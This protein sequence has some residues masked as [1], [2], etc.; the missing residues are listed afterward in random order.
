M[1]KLIFSFLIGSLSM[2][3]FANTMTEDLMLSLETDQNFSMKAKLSPN[4]KITAEISKNGIMQQCSGSYK[5][6]ISK[7]VIVTIGLVLITFEG[8]CSAFDMAGSFE[9]K[10]LEKIKVGQSMDFLF[11]FLK[12]INSE[13]MIQARIDMIKQ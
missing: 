11:M 9:P 5:I 6:E 13:V 3:T 1:K 7:V 12:D 2:A 10:D 8:E 4:N